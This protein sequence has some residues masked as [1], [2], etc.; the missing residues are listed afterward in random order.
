MIDVTVDKATET[1][2]GCHLPKVT[3]LVSEQIFYLIFSLLL[4]LLSLA[5]LFLY[6]V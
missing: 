6:D 3:Q 2:R 4:L 1:W 5:F